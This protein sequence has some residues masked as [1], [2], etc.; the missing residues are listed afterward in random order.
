MKNKLVILIGSSGFLGKNLKQ[1]L[2]KKIKCPNK[3]QL[4]LKK[5]NSVLNYLKRF[6]K[7]KN[8]IIINCACHVGNVHYGS[9]YPADII[10]D[11]SLMSLNLYKA[12]SS[13]KNKVKIIN[14]FANC[15]YPENSSIQKEENWL[16]GKPHESVLSYGSYKRFLYALSVAYFKQHGIKSINWMF[17]GGYGPY[18]SI[19]EEKEHALNGMIIRMIKSKR[20]K[21]DKFVVWGSGKPIREWVFIKDMANI[22]K[23]SIDLDNL[24]YPVNFGQKKGY[25]IAQ[26]AKIIKNELRLNSKLVFDK[27]KK[28]GDKKK[29]LDNKNF[30]KIHPKFK[31]T[32]LKKG[33]SQTIKYFEKAI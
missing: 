10:F 24:I 2:S 11:N 26:T 33:I 27:S 14:P 17:G 16:T 3:N 25:S 19:N 1:V 6:N 30:K 5:Y 22:I 9:K 28:D 29:V 31:F 7:V 12:C 21:K 4:N 18:A 20:D 15:S 32:S 8:L 23:L 13:L